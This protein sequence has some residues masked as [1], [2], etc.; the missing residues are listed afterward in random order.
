MS[1]GFNKPV[2][3][4]GGAPVY[5]PLSL[6]GILVALMPDG[7][8]K[9]TSGRGHATVEIANFTF[10]DTGNP[11]QPTHSNFNK[12]A[13]QMYRDGDF[14]ELIRERENRQARRAALRKAA[15]DLLAVLEQAVRFIEDC[16][17]QPSHLDDWKRLIKEH[18]A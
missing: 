7:T 3:N 8:V 10:N 6:N 1:T 4:W 12:T 13:K 16:P 9:A 17:I 14:D 15:P 2:T 18:K 5:P 11:W